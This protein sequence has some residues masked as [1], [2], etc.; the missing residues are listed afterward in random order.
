MK[1]VEL[2]GL[3]VVLAMLIV[4]TTGI[5]IMGEDVLAHHLILCASILAATGSLLVEPEKD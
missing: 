4:A 1:R 2:R 5:I 3:Q